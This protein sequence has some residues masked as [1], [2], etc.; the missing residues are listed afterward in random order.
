[1]AT[2]LA[3]YEVLLERDTF[4]VERNDRMVSLSVV[5]VM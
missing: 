2:F 4:I 5:K 3:R 1:M